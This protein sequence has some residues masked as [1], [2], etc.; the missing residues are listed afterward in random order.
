VG[1]LAV[2]VAS[3]VISCGLHFEAEAMFTCDLWP[4]DLQMGSWVVSDIGFIPANFKLAIP[5][6]SRLRFRYRTD[7]WTDRQTM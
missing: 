4:F 2:G 1:P 7:R 6:R 5:F 3:N